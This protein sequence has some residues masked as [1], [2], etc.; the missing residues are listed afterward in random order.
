MPELTY[1]KEKEMKDTEKIMEI[2]G[3]MPDFM[4]NYHDSINKTTEPSS[5]LNYLRDLLLF[6]EYI[7]DQENFD[8][9]IKDITPDL[10]GS[11]S[12]DFLN[13]YLSDLAH[14][15][16]NGR[17]LTNENVSLSRKQSSLRSLYNYL[18]GSDLIQDNPTAKDTFKNYKTKKKTIVRM[19]DEETRE[20]LDTVEYGKNLTGQRAAYHDKY[21][22]RDTALLS[23]MLG[24]GIRVSEC[25][26]LNI[27]DIDLKHH[28]MK[29]IRKG[30]KEDI[31]YYSDEVTEILRDYIYAYRKKLVPVDGHEDALFLSSQRKRI[32]VRSI[33]R[34]VEK[35]AADNGMIKH[36]TAHSLRK[37]FGSRL[38]EASSDLYLVAETL[39]H[40]SVETTK[41]HY[42]DITNKHKEENRNILS[43]K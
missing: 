28:C 37:S 20:F 29:V 38:Y 9:K 7:S 2:L 4:K 30:N 17:V 27:N 22:F 33:E 35:Y 39:G 8:I 26:G 10:L 24:T 13:H 25:A 42:A 40:S 21:A 12:T 11:L 34:L 5:R 6:F 1:K 15:R 19:D 31:V 14:Y 18:Y 43:L 23:L 32:S 3:K 41:R 36:I 16:R